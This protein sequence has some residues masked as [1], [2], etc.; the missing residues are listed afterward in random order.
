MIKERHF[1]KKVKQYADGKTISITGHSLG[2]GIAN[3]VALR[4]QEDDI[5]VFGAKSSTSFKSRCR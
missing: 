2:G 3:T 5:D 4:H 1:T